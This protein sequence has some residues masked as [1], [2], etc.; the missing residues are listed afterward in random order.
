[1]QRAHE[2]V[3]ETGVAAGGRT[4]AEH[5][6]FCAVILVEAVDRAS[7]HVLLVWVLQRPDCQ[8]KEVALHRTLRADRVE[9]GELDGLDALDVLELV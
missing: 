4:R 1:M 9:V 7:N 8:I 2:V 6:F 3:A 5:A